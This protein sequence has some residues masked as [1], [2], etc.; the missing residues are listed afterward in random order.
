[1]IIPTPKLLIV[2]EIPSLRK[3]LRDH[4]RRT[5]YQVF[6]AMEGREA[7]QNFGSAIEDGDFVAIISGV[8]MLVMSEAD[9]AASVR[10][11]DSEA[12]IFFVT[13]GPAIEIEKEQVFT[14]PDR[15]SQLAATILRHVAPA[16]TIPPPSNPVEGS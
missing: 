7:L 11:L 9:F 1:L 15:L 2:A 10:T 12:R 13:D 4:F 5:G 6:T 8:K 16:G 14:V 3:I